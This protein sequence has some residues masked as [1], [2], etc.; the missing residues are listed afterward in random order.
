MPL[1]WHK[2]AA[3]E[4]ALPELQRIGRCFWPHQTQ[5]SSMLADYLA[6][7]ATLTDWFAG[8]W[9][10]TA[11][12][13]AA[14]MP[15]INR[16]ALIQVL[17]QSLQ[18]RQAPAASQAAVTA[19]AQDNCGLIA[20]WAT[21]RLRRWSPIVANQGH[22]MPKSRRGITRRGPACQALFWVASD[23]HD[24]DEANR[25]D[26]VHRDG[27]VQRLRCRY[28]TPG[29]ALHRQ[30]ASSGWSELIAAIEAMP[31]SKLGLDWLQAYAPENGEGLGRWFAR[32]IEQLC[33]GLIVIEAKDLRSLWA[34]RL[35][36]LAQQWPAQALAQRSAE[37]QAAGYELAF[38]ELSQ[39][40]LFCDTPEQRQP[41]QAEDLSNEALSW[42]PGAALRPV[43]Q[44]AIMPVIGWVAGPGELR[45]HAQL[46]PIYQALSVQMPRFIARRQATILP[47]WW[48]RGANGMGH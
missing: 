5:R 39:A 48:Q 23:D 34:S 27:R 35:G 40:P 20:C 19:L 47:S 8:P 30:D 26:L 33:P 25:C 14:P 1:V 11:D 10:S 29:A 18:D 44:Q 7:D 37:I 15:E 12:L 16:P 13:L 2:L 36:E 17:Q 41:W 4:Q 3:G 32:L 45:Y 21:A 46:S 38:D 24:H 42:S 9:R 22:R 31:D 43:L 28:A 6:D